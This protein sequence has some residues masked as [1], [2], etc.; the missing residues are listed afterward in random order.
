MSQEPQAPESHNQTAPEPEPQ[1]A[2]LPPKHPAQEEQPGPGK[3]P[4]LY[5]PF[6]PMP[7]AEPQFSQPPAPIEP[8]GPP[9]PPIDDFRDPEDIPTMAATSRLKPFAPKAKEEASPQADGAAVQSAAASAAGEVKS[10]DDQG[11]IPEAAGPGISSEAGLSGALGSG[12]SLHD[13]S[14]AVAGLSLSAPGGTPAK[15]GNALTRGLS[16]TCRSIVALWKKIPPID[17]LFDMLLTAL[18][19]QRKPDSMLRRAQSLAAKGRHADAIKWFREILNLRPLTVAAYDGLG[20]VY[21]RMGLTEEANREFTVAD[22]LERLVNNRDD[23]DAAC[24]LSTALLERKQAKM[25]VSLL[26]PVLVAHFYTPNNANL[27]KK[28]GLV[29]SELRSTKKLYQVYEA[30]LAQYPNDHEF[31]ILKGNIDIKLGRVAE[32]EKLIRFGRLMGRLKEDPTD[33]NANMSMGE[34]CIK[35]DRLQEGLTFLREAASLSP[36]NSG[37]RWRLFNLYQKLGSYQ[38]ALHYFLEVIDIEPDNEDLKYKLAE[39]YRKNRRFDEAQAIYE[40]LAKKH[41]REPKMRFLLSSLL[42]ETGRFEESQSLRTLA[43]TLAIG[44]KK[45]PDHHD[46]VIFMKYLFSIGQNTEAEE[47]LDRG[48]AK[49]PYHG[50]LIITKVKI[51][52]NEYRYKEA[53]TLLKRLISVKNDLAEPHMFMAMC[54]QRLGN[55]MAALAEAQLATRLAPKSF[56]SHKVLGDILKEQKKVSQANAAYEVA[57]MI[58]LSLKKSGGGH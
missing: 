4:E 49:W 21:F 15:S 48:L 33:V 53:V 22:S 34:L 5:N 14:G 40:D 10:S 41:P 29:Y 3:S 26:E 8:E 42:N 9:L 36:G 27:L 11:S 20:R 17:D 18:G 2:A 16:A 35:E 39:F 28:M 23:L 57:N 7:P 50:E 24:S 54:Y 31:Y 32:G 30:G 56:T 44:L 46:I 43:E 45:D 6:G 47:W 1:P 13:G 12:G 19:F 25:A 55:H 37:I 51:L 52:Y 38:D 58:Q